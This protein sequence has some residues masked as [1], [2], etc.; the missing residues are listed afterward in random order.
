MWTKSIKIS[1]KVYLITCLH[2]CRQ[3][4]GISTIPLLKYK[5]FLKLDV[6]Y[7]MWNKK[8]YKSTLTLWVITQRCVRL[9]EDGEGCVWRG[10]KDGRKI[11]MTRAW[12]SHALFSFRPSTDRIP[13]FIWSIK[14]PGYDERYVQQPVILMSPYSGARFVCLFVCLFSI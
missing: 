5:Q 7:K 1:T 13:V 4:I 14:N 10:L 2:V 6:F 12:G 11:D 8:S 9:R 3:E